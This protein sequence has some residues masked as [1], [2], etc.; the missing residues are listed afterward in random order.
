MIRQIMARVRP[1]RETVA[2]TPVAAAT[3]GGHTGPRDCHLIDHSCGKRHCSM[4]SCPS[5]AAAYAARH[6]S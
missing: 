1:N 2:Q 3:C 5:A 6:G 4:G